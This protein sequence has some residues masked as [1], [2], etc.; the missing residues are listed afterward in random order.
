MAQTDR[1][2]VPSQVPSSGGNFTVNRR[3]AS[4]VAT[5]VPSHSLA[6]VPGGEDPFVTGTLLVSFINICLIYCYSGPS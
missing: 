3:E 2:N 5:A 6:A 4:A 1:T